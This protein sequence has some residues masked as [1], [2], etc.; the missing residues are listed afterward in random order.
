[1]RYLGYTHE[2]LVGTTREQAY[3]RG[4]QI[5][6]MLIRGLWT[7]GFGIGFI[8]E[9]VHKFFELVQQQFLDLRPKDL[10]MSRKYV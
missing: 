6:L 2:I 1:M 7:G 8:I 4:Y 3:D 9:K 5:D 10:S